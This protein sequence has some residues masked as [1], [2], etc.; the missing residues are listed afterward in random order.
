[1]REGDTAI[2]AAPR[3]G[4]I[5]LDAAKS[6]LVEIK[7]VAG[8]TTIRPALAQAVEA[9][10]AIAS[11]ENDDRL[12]DSAGC[13]PLFRLRSDR[14]AID[15]L[16]FGRMV[17]LRHRQFRILRLKY[18]VSDFQGASTVADLPMEAGS[19]PSYV[20]VFHR[21]AGRSPL[22]VDGMTSRFLELVDGRK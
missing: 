1:S 2:A 4:E 16:D 9:E 21:E 15:Q 18:D 20:V 10:I 19:H 12:R 14:W 22:I 8:S 5:D 7:R 13:D 3:N 17:P 6:L 11:T